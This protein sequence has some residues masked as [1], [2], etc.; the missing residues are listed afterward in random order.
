MAD[1]TNG[2][3]VFQTYNNAGTGVAELG[4]NRK[5]TEGQ[6]IAGRTVIITLSQTNMTQANLDEVLTLIQAGGT[7]GTDDAM[8]VVGVSPNGVD[9]TIFPSASDTIRFESG[10][11][12]VV[13][14]ALQGTGNVTAGS[15]YRGTGYT[16][17][18]IAVFDQDA[19]AD[20]TGVNTTGQTSGNF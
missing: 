8:T 6:G 4:D 10:V 11:T 17:A 2:S 12:D 7:A 5:V 13:T 20:D 1:L 16:M 3:G 14:V 15:S 9:G 18:V 19:G